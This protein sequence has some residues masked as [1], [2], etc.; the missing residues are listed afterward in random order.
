VVEG[1]PE[2]ARGV[3]VTRDREWNP[4]HLVIGLFD[5]IDAEAVAVVARGARDRS[6][7][8]LVLGDA[9]AGDRPPLSPAAERAEIVGYVR[10]VS[11]T[12]V[13]DD[14]P[15]LRGLLDAAGPQVV[16]T[17]LTQTPLIGGHRADRG[18]AAPALIRATA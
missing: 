5:P 16:V 18:P 13:V 8:A 11:E 3:Q 2:C 7:T 12:V 6:V 9:F 1:E 4:A 14:L 15:N 17:W 10:G